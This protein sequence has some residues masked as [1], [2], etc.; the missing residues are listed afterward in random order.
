MTVYLVFVRA[1]Y[2][3]KNKVEVF[4]T[5]EAAKEYFDEAIKNEKENR[6]YKENGSYIEDSFNNYWCIYKRGNFCEDHY[7]VELLSRELK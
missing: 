7:E 2:A 1:T 5:Y 3:Y 4:S 6:N